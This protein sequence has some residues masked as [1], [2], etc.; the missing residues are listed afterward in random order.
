V[1]VQPYPSWADLLPAVPATARR[2]FAHPD[3]ETDQPDHQDH[4]R[5]PP[6]DANSESQPAQYEG[7][8]KDQKNDADEPIP[9]ACPS[10]AG[11][12]YPAIGDIPTTD[13]LLPPSP[14]AAF[15]SLWPRPR[16]ILKHRPGDPSAPDLHRA[17]GTHRRSFGTKL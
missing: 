11:S 3:D 15:I 5:D 9:S 2:A 4:Q 17:S 12:S 6:Q 13:R 10:K 7:E 8:K 1:P 14:A 16:R